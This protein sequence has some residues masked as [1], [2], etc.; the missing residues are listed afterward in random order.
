MTPIEII[1]LAFIIFSATK[2]AVLFIK[3]TSWYG[4]PAGAFWVKPAIAYPGILALGS[5]VLWYLLAELTITQVLAAGVFGFLVYMLD[6]TPYTGKL[7][8]A[9]QSDIKSGT[10]ILCKNW[11]GTFVWVALMVWA[12]WEIFLR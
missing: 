5:V 1:A 12:L 8:G 2:I 9:I 4:G 11:V 10:N 7:F 3:P 6:I